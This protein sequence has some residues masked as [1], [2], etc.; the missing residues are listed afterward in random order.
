MNEK[1][2]NATP[3]TGSI[4]AKLKKTSA[5]AKAKIVYGGFLAFS[6]FPIIYGGNWPERFMC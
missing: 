6:M 2:G 1:I 3:A 5:S 4:L